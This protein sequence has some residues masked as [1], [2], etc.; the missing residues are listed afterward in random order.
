M[1]F[2]ESQGIETMLLAAA[3]TELLLFGLALIKLL[4][5]AD[6]TLYDSLRTGRL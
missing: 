2:D 5:A 1:A 3:V 4:A 6:V